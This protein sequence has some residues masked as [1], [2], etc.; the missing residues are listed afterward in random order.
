MLDLNYVRENLSAV[1]A[2]MEKR[3]FP[4]SALD[5]FERIDGERRRAIAESDELNRQRNELS[6]QVGA[7]MKENKPEQAQA[8]RQLVGEIK[9]KMVELERQRDEGET[10]MRSSK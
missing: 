3:K 8:Q 9:E 2:A 5:D 7:L 4:L 10:R 1:R 6:R